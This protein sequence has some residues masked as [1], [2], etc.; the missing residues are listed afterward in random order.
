MTMVVRPFLC[1]LALIS[2]KMCAAARPSLS[3]VSAVTGSTLATPRTPSVPKILVACFTAFTE[4]LR[5]Q[6]VN[7]KV[8]SERASLFWLVFAIVVAQKN[9]FVFK[10]ESDCVP[11]QRKFLQDLIAL[12]NQSPIL[13]FAFGDVAQFV[14]A[15]ADRR[16]IN[17]VNRSATR[18]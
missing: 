15:S 9:A 3:A 8:R 2:A 1:R 16:E 17:T 11:F 14:V 6:F 13:V 18:F 5:C 4:T 12:N 7:G 10:T